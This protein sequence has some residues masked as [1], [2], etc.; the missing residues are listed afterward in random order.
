MRGK[1][2][3]KHPQMVS[4][5][6]NG[7]LHNTFIDQV[8]PSE[9]LLNSEKISSACNFTK[10][11]QIYKILQILQILQILIVFLQILLLG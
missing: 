9:V 5:Q 4:H 8:F 7:L 6:M 3:K 2:Q 11:L 10:K 1:K